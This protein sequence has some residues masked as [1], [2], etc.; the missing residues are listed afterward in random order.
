MKLVTR[1]ALAILV[2]LPAICAIPIECQA[3]VTTNASKGLYELAIS[4]TGPI[5]KTETFDRDPNWEGFYN[6]MKP[7]DAREVKQNFGYARTHFAGKMAGEMGGVIWRSMTPAHYGDRLAPRTLN[8]RLT[9]TGSFAL[10]DSSGGDGI[11]FGWFNARQQG[12]RP[13]N[14][15]GF[16]LD[17]QSDYAIVHVD[18]TTGTWKAGGLNTGI[19][20]RSDRSRHTFKLIYD[21]AANRG[22]GAIS[23]IIDRRRPVT[24]KLDP[25]HKAEGA[26][27][28]RF[29]MFNVQ[30]YGGPMTVYFDDL[31][32]NG[33]ME[34][35]A[36]DP[37]WDAKGNHVWFVDQDKR[38]AQNFGFSQTSFTGGAPGEVGGTFWRCPI[39]APQSYYADR[40]G[41]LT[42]EKPLFASGS[43]AF[44]RASSDSCLMFGWF[45][46]ETARKAQAERAG[47]I[48]N[49]VGVV[50][51]GPS[52]V[53]HYFDP[54]Y[55]TAGGDGARGDTDSPVI[56]PDGRARTW[57]LSYDPYANGGAGAIDASLDGER[58]TLNLR[59]GG[60]AQGATFDRFG[61]MPTRPDGHGL[62]VYWD[63]LKYTKT[64]PSEH[65]LRM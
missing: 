20:I 52:R 65:K 43:I 27:F 57:T 64:Y 6:R 12:F 17:G 38:P 5:I 46:S 55:V 49:F 16:R 53:G 33:K 30:V 44:T 45:N 48:D 58:V 60:K 35:F 11:F 25:G 47:S 24:L 54:T 40:I 41:P 59:P 36:K 23:L 18:Y 2:L 7:E 14:F 13:V 63:D 37:K 32:Y 3:V 56:R 50:I 31:K 26:A 29:G 62:S 51:G 21:P 61:I 39:D 34:T 22:G 4:S 9:A 10:T 1:K 15:V 19:R 8:D 42:L 28:N